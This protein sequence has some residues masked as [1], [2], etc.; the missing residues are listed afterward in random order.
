MYIEWNVLDMYMCVLST[1]ALAIKKYKYNIYN[2]CNIVDSDNNPNKPRQQCDTDVY[3][4]NTFW[5]ERKLIVYY[6][7]LLVY[8]III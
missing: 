8:I 4:G 5:I 1:R 2:N 6:P 7:K 3:K